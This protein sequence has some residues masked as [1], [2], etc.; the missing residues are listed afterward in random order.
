MDIEDLKPPQPSV[1]RIALLDSATSVAAFLVVLFV[2]TGACFLTSIPAGL[3]DQ[4]FWL[5]FDVLFFLPLLLGI[6]FLLWRLPR[7][8]RHIRQV[9]DS[10]EIVTG[11]ITQMMR[12]T[13]YVPTRVFYTYDYRGTTYKASQ[14]VARRFQPPDSGEIRVIVNPQN[15][16]EVLVPTAFGS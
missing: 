16:N 3:R 14:A 15:P 7:R 2:L 5:L 12:G 10:G 9:W 1:L 6:P 8:A 11:K 4:S 13:R